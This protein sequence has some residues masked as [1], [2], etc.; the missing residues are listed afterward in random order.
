[1]QRATGRALSLDGPIHITR[2][3]DPW[4][5][6][7]RVRLANLPGGSRSYMVR[8]DRIRAQVSLL[9][10][11]RQRIEITHLELT[12]P[13]ILLEEVRGQPNW[14]FQSTGT[15]P[16]PAN[17]SANAPA[18]APANAHA[19]ASI[20]GWFHPKLRIRHLQIVNG[21]ITSRLPA[22]TNVIG[23]RKLDVTHPRDDA[24]FDLTSTLVYSD[25]APFDLALTAAPTGKLAA[26][27]RTTIHFSAFD[28]HADAT[29]TMTLGGNYDLAVTA[30]APALEALNALLPSMHLPPLHDFSFETHISNG[31]V[32]GDL[33]VVGQTKLHIGSADLTR[34]VAGLTLGTVD[35]TLDKA[36]GTAR[37]KGQGHYE[38]EPFSLT[39]AAGVPEHLDGPSTVPVTLATTALATDPARLHLEGKLSLDTT[40]FAGLVAQVKLDT[41]KLARLRPLI[42]PALPALA[43]AHFTGGVSLPADLKT[44]GI[45]GARLTASAGDL[46]GSAS[47]GLGGG[48][49]VKARLTSTRLDLDALLKAVGLGIAPAAP[50]APTGSAG[51][52]FSHNDLSFWASLRGPDIDVSGDVGT[53]TFQGQSWQK[54]GLI[55][56]L[57]NG[58]LVLDRMQAALAGG[59]VEG[60]LT[61]DAARKTPTMHLVLHAPDVPVALL[62]RR[63]GLPGP[64]SGALRVNADLSAAGASAHALAGSLA[65]SFSA[66]MG[67]GSISN[68]AL[69]DL[70][71]ASLKA[72]NITVPREG[73]TGIRCFGVVGTVSRGVARLS[74]VA[75]NSTYLQLHGHG[76]VD[77]G[78]ETLALKLRPLARVSG[79]SVSVPV[80]V[81]GPFRAVKGQLDAGAL[82]KAGILLDA[83]FG[84]DK[85]KTCAENGLRSVPG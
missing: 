30:A 25:F 72:L 82:Q 75:L 29:G 76:E 57:R 33:P 43:D 39:G 23:I 85:S 5:E 68:Q 66:T 13:N 19:G 62:V 79:S 35:A 54:V 80:V 59:A 37:V 18:N 27:W 3:L 36:G 4:I 56:R 73:E 83:L 41:P 63:A 28:A 58:H 17:A 1:M 20:P 84:G 40:T 44:L 48:V 70:A 31:P 64:A 21:M 69:L 51:P 24:P 14:L 77:L 15:A 34:I 10:L 26:P 81:N 50:T 52:V 49:A 65:G 38:K 47:F 22:R 71:G 7:S 8:M 61:V 42:S 45:S 74:T 2:S 46:A 67:G 53:L 78:Q 60:S 55:V 32:R 6:V 12:G 11:L 16:A 9:A